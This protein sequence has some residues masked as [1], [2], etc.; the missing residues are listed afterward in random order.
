MRVHFI[1][2]GGSAMHDLA[3][4][5]HK[6][7]YR[8]SGSDDAIFE[9]SRSRLEEHGL[10][11]PAMGWDPSR[12]SDELDRV[13]LGMHAKKDNPE[14]LR[15]HEH[16]I[17][18]L[19]FPEFIAERS[20]GKERVVI[21]GSHGKT[22]IT[23]MILH[24]LRRQG[25]D[26]DRLIGAQLEGYE[27]AVRLSEEADRIVIE[28]DEYLSSP[29][30]PRSKFL[31]YEPHLAL[32]SG[33]SWDHVNVFPS[34]DDYLEAFRRLLLS[35]PP[36]STLIHCSEDEELQRLVREH[37]SHL[38]CIPYETHP[39]FNEEEGSFLDTEI[40]ALPLRIFGSHNMQN[41]AG[42][43]KVC[44]RSG[45]PR[46][47]FYQ[48]IRDFEG[49]SLRM[50][51]IQRKGANLAFRDYA[52]A[53]SKVKATVRAV[54]ERYPG[55]ALLACVELHTYSSLDPDFIGNYAGSME[56]AEEAFV[57]FDPSAAAKKGFGELSAE[58]IRKAFQRPDLEIHSDMEALEKV[59]LQRASEYGSKILLFMSSGPFQGKDLSSFA[60]KCFC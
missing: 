41:L 10:L 48:A 2:I 42:A 22:S 54:K 9:P 17:P 33:I 14:L 25:M 59:L 30:D 52:H 4:A 21:A 27:G 16:G 26:P 13:I 18:V 6:R 24:V 1:A 39:H 45:V 28:G 11:P 46:E 50:E 34:F 53:P 5:L 20:Q 56:G 37:A 60:W 7:G 58:R 3:I 49:A 23:A 55:R 57:F 32:I 40:G 36:E 35:M 31:W 19:S 15:A 51:E 12:I 43:L 29:I 8:V 44:E 38:H 47:N